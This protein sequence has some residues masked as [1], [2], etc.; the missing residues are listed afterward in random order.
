M[1]KVF[2]GIDIG[3]SGCRGI[4]IDINGELIA[5]QHINLPNPKRNG[6]EVEQEPQIWWEALSTVLTQ[7]SHQLSEPIA[8]LAIDGT[9]ATVLLADKHGTPLGP[10]LMYNDARAIQQAEQIRQIAPPD[11]GAHGATSSL[12]KLLWLL[13]H[14]QP[15]QVL[16]Q[17]DWLIA[18][19]AGQ[20]LG[21]DENNCLKMGYDPMTRQWPN[22]IA[23][24][25]ID[26][27]LLPQVH[28]PGTPI[29][30]I[31]KKIA[32]TI[33]L[34]PKTL[35]ISGT[36]DSIA[37][38]LATEA[39]QLGEA[40]TSLGSTLALKIVSDKPIFS[41]ESGI[42]S[43]RLWDKWLAGGASNTG[44]A[45]LL[46]YFSPKALEQMTPELQP[47]Q[48]TQLDYYPLLSVGERFPIADPNQQPCTKPRPTDDVRFFQGLLESIA[49]IEAEGYRRLQSL[50]APYPKTLYT[51][52]GGAKNAAW[53]E[54]RQNRLGIQIHTPPHTQAAYGAARLARR[55]F[56]I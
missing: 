24:L 3:T 40:V 14:H 37:A 13:K 20:S 23:S 36:T 35:L 21:S 53:T 47:D 45:I 26:R 2:V 49:R 32:T 8:A 11:S 5:E 29:G 16:H 38:F 6:V 46:K 25:G 10:A 44:G 51:V 1:S 27:N 22:W 54:I 31:D 15:Y 17:A 33:G 4:A 42:Y 7:L 48:P 9:S 18:K 34:N 30:T 12:A 43:H 55:G 50:G 52:G 19:L 56:L 28:P 39:E 41:A